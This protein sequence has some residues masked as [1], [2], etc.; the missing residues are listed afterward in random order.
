MKKMQKMS[1]QQASEYN[2]NS[3]KS[4][5]SALNRHLQDLGRDLDIVRGRE[6]RSSNNILDGKLKKNLEEGLARPT[7]HK[8]I[9][10]S[11][12]LTKMWSYLNGDNDPIAL[13]F[14]VWFQLSVHFVSR[15]LEFHEQLKINSL[16]VKKDE[17]GNE[18]VTLTHETRQKNWQGG[19]DTSENQKEKRMYA[20]EIAGDSCPVKSLLLF[21]SKTDRNATSLFNRCIKQALRSPTNEETWYSNIPLKKYQ[22]TRFMADIS[23]NAHFLRATAIQGMND[24][25]FEVRH[26]MHMSGHKNEASVRS[27]NRDCS[28]NQKK[29]LSDSLASLVVPPTSTSDTSQFPLVPLTRVPANCTKPLALTVND[30]VTQSQTVALN[31]SNVMSSGFISNSSFNNCVFNFGNN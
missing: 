26:I 18:F 21:L 17:N 3:Y 15:G 14:R 8:Q 20:V 12:E 4:I 30:T 13:R 27:Y 7:Q 10:P 16:I 5:R 2:H 19:I 11:P 28:T 9:I 29:S 22:F 24:A 31:S 23:K 25:G 1:L 6:F